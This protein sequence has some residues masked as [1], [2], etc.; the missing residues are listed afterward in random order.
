MWEENGEFLPPQGWDILPLGDILI[1]EEIVRENAS[2]NNVSFIEEL[3]LMVAHGFLHLLGLDHDTEEKKEAMWNL[4]FRIRENW[5]S[6]QRQGVS[7]IEG[8]L[9]L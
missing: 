4:Q 3:Y 1:C 2:Q 5:C 6:E 8:G 7:P 9:I